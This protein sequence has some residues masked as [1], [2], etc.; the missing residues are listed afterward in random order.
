VTHQQI[1]S[2]EQLNASVQEAIARIRTMTDRAK[3][4]T[5]T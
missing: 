2:V 4:S 1:A 3:S 5:S